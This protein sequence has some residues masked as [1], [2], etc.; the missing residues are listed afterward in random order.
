LQWMK[1]MGISSNH[2]RMRTN[3]MS[4]SLPLFDAWKEVLGETR[5]NFWWHNGA[6]ILWMQME[7]DF[8]RFVL[9]VG[10][11]EANT[12]VDFLKMVEAKGIPIKK[13]GLKLDAQLTRLFSKR[14]PY[15]EEM[16][17]LFEALYADEDL[18]A[19]LRVFE[20]LYEE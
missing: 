9:E 6:F 3:F 18:Q 15:E 10:P 14:V 8:L 13:Q 2:Y 19:I 17:P 16:L 12:R 1:Q 20:E 11:I 5:E 4:F 7:E